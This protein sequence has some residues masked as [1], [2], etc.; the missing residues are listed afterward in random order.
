M[1][2]TE[3]TLK[4]IDIKQNFLNVYSYSGGSSV[5]T[6]DGC[7]DFEFTYCQSEQLLKSGY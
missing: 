3:Y 7:G 1:A 2:Y 4:F 5:N 6:S